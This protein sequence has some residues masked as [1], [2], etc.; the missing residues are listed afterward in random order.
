[1]GVTLTLTVARHSPVRHAQRDYRAAPGGKSTGASSTRARVP[2]CIP[3]LT[4]E[5]ALAFET[6]IDRFLAAPLD[7]VREYLFLQILARWRHAPC[8][9]DQACGTST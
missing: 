8:C 7:V 6:G 1:M 4:R 5:V 2:F 9:R 3:V